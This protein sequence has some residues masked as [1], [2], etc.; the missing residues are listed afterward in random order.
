M[1]STPAKAPNYTE[2]QE[3]RLREVY[4]A[5]PTK[6]SVETLAEEMGK[7]HRSIISKLSNMGI[8]V[9]PP[10]L[11]KAG[12]PIVKKE[13]LV[14]EIMERLEVNAPSLVKANK[15]DLERLVEATREL[16]GEANG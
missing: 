11:T 3:Q 10:R 12:T 8:Y 14:A 16:T 7:S 13:A 1:T 15:Q 5:E 2:K 9:T 4:G 6:E